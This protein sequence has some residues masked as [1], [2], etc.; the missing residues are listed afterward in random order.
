MQR[1]FSSLAVESQD[2]ENTAK[3]QLLKTFLHADQAAVF[4][5]TAG[6]G[7]PSSESGC[8]Q[9]T[10]TEVPPVHVWRP[11]PGQAH[12]LQAFLGRVL[13]HFRFCVTVHV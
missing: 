6:L 7:S 9:S 10:P 2:I 5:V 12:P 4:G 13:S 8:S 1:L 3:T 11:A